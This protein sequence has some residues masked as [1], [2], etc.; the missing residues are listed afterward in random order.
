MNKVFLS[1]RTGKDVEVK[2]LESGQKKGA[3]SF[4]TIQKIIEDTGNKREL[5]EWH[6]LI[7]WGKM[8]DTW[9]CYIPKGTALNIIGNIHYNNWEKDGVKHYKTEINVES[10]EFQNGNKKLDAVVPE[11]QSTPETSPD[12]LPF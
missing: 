12:D 7:I 5:T 8:V 6:N 1:G 10:F 2:K 3:V 4:A 11:A 9:E